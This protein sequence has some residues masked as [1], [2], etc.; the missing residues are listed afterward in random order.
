MTALA[1]IVGS[2]LIAKGRE[3]GMIFTSSVASTGLAWFSTYSASKEYVSMLATMFRLEWRDVCIDGFCLEP[4]LTDTEMKSE[5]LSSMGWPVSSVDDCVNVSMSGLEKG[6]LRGT[7]GMDGK[8]EED[9][10]LEKGLT[11]ISDI[12]KTNWSA[13]RFYHKENM[14]KQ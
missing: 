10:A 5:D 12:M 3:G 13:E 11:A 4:G 1:H 6:L 2:R 8:K 9:D 14:D 7:P